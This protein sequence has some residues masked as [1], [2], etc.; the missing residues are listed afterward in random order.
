MTVI[1]KTEMSYVKFRM[2]RAWYLARG[3]RVGRGRRSARK[4]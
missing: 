3:K 2:V 1:F 4:E